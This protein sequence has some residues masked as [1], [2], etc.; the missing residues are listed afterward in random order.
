[1]HRQVR[2]VTLFVADEPVLP[3][4]LTSGRGLPERVGVLGA[5][6]DAPRRSH[7]ARRSIVSL[8]LV[9][10]GAGWIRLGPLPA[11]VLSAH[12][13]PL[14]LDHNGRPLG[15]S[16]ATDDAAGGLVALSLRAPRLSSA[17]LVAEDERFF[18]HAGVDPTALVRA[19][20][21]AVRRQRVTQGG[22]T[23][24]QQLVKLR[25]G[26][27][28][29][30]RGV[31]GKVQEAV[32]ALRLEQ[33]TLKDA[34]LSA[35]LAEAPYGARVTG[36]EAA[37]RLYFGVP[38][39]QLSWAQAAY[40][41]ALPQRP[42]AFDP[43]RRPKAAQ[44]RAHWI[45]RRLRDSHDIDTRTYHR[46][47]AEKIVVVDRPANDLAPHFSEMLERN[48]RATGGAGG[49]VT[50]T[51]DAVLQADVQRLASELRNERRQNGAANVAVVV[52]DNAT[53]A[54]RAW[55]GSGGY[56]DGTKGGQIDGVVTPRQTGSTIKPLV[57]A[58][59]FENGAR[60]EDL[61]EDDAVSLSSGNGT[62]FR[63]ENYDHRHRGT[64]TLREA[65]ASSVNVAAVKLARDEG[66]NE[67]ASFL[68]RNNLPLH[69]PPATYGL[70]LALGAAEQDLLS[71]TRAYATIARGGTP[72]KIRTRESEPVV[73]GTRTMSAVTAY[74][75]TDVL[76]DNEARATAFGRNSVLRFPFEV[77][78]KTGTSQDFRDNWV[79]GYTREFTVGVW[80]G[81]F[82]RVPLRGATGVTGAGPL[83]H[84]V[85]LAARDRLT[86]ALGTDAVLAV[87]P[88]LLH[89]GCAQ[90]PCGL[91]E[92]RATVEPD[93]TAERRTLP[94]G[95]AVRP[96]R[97]ADLLLQR[98]VAGARYVIDPTRPI[99]GQRVPLRAVGGTGPY[100]YE[101]D[102]I[103]VQR[104]WG[105]ETGAHEA[106][107]ID[108]SQ[109]RRCVRFFV[110]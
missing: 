24:S 28:G 26:R 43:W 20:V 80:V 65:L 40:L 61:I 7:W 14:Y 2:D 19:G 57:Y 29:V 1:V 5:P 49:V 102:G 108:A 64:I 62:T 103:V 23:I 48:R 88:A 107:A 98:P 110:R 92:Q 73:A 41:A 27:A 31:V 71:M 34:I 67:L 66:V 93:G 82:D 85:V 51:L 54:V 10:V 75:L 101:V 6:F 22:S 32:Y 17:T 47:L 100:R 91:R 15:W 70:S 74:E 38:P 109:V 84:A 55:E 105:L 77:A 21:S 86:P 106:C 76:S 89:A 60:P 53:G 18:G 11:R 99:E 44:E 50:T 69:S 30:R 37:A 25:L 87:R 52:I 59:A 63:P 90:I 58:L 95:G 56:A 97:G 4:R 39:S 94:G 68:A 16:L 33:H 8:V 72:I 83:F 36:A 42:T 79:I 78:A 96:R 13:T 46:A 104:S 35:Y 81:N 3:I 45:L 9:V 12:R